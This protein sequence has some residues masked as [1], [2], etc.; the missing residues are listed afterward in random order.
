[1]AAAILG[2]AIPS[3]GCAQIITRSSVEVTP[4]TETSPLAIP[5]GGEISGRGLE[6]TWTQ[7][8]DRLSVHL[9][10]SRTCDSVRYVPVVRIERVDRRTAGGAMW[11]EYGLGAAALSGGLVGLI[12]P[13][14]F[15][16]ASTVNADGMVIKDKGTGYRIGGVLTGIGSVLLVAAVVDTVRTRNEVRYTDAYRRDPGGRIECRDPLV[17]LQAQTV[18]LLVDEWSTV[19]PTNQD[20]G[21]R[22]LLPAVEELPEAAREVIAATEVWEAAK[23]EADAAAKAAAEEAA[24]VAA[25]AEAA[26][27]KQKKG[28]KAKASDPGAGASAPGPE[29]VVAL[30]PRPEPLVVKAVLRIDP[31]RALGV[32]FVVPYADETARGHQ[33][34]VTVEPGPGGPVP[35]RGKGLS[36]TAS[37][38]RGEASEPSPSEPTTS[39]PGEPVEEP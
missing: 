30:G 4:R 12:R 6:A 20:G 36:L 21:V 17:P 13:E 31:K 16:Q 24:R 18:E 26:A 1:M 34:H 32:T 15:S 11:L 38:A 14:L 19:E 5:P 28:R 22:F 8:G 9:E 23:A 39:E 7:D 35:G 37:G 10:E 27:A 2:V 25:E 3:G 29:P 33:G